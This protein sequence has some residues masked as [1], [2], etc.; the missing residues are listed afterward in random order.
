[1]PSSRGSSGPRIEPASPALTGSFFN[2]SATWEALKE[3]C[4]SSTVGHL[5]Q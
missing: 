1:M 2:A 3:G 4:Q 5:V